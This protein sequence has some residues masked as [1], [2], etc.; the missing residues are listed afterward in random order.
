MSFAAVVTFMLILDESGLCALSLFCCII[1]ELGHIVCLFILGEK[2]SLL[3]LSFY[4]IKLERKNKISCAV[5]DIIIF[6]AGP[7]MNLVF[8]VLLLLAGKNEFAAAASVVSAAVGIFNLV[9]C[10]PL[11]GGNILFTLLCR[12][13][14]LDSSEKI[15][16]TVS[17][18]FVALLF[19][20][21]I[22]TIWQNG[23]FT[24]AAVSL[25]LASLTFRHKIEKDAIKL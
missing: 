7:C 12:H 24:L 1:H 18:V 16:F 2:P 22:V 11:D 14:S 9:P 4:G 20:S 10:R 6:V 23:N 25:Y 13:M 21:G 3:E 15:S 19:V 8:S 5:D 17:A